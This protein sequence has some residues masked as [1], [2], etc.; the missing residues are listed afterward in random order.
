MRQF[1][2]ILYGSFDRIDF[3]RILGSHGHSESF[4]LVMLGWYRFHVR[5][6]VVVVVV[7]G[8]GSHGFN[9]QVYI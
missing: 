4:L 7:V 8:T 5:L 6:A 3:D 1:H 9:D 2:N